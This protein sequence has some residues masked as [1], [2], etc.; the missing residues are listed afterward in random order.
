MATAW[1]SRHQA[2][3]ST[4]HSYPSCAQVCELNRLKGELFSFGNPVEPRTPSSSRETLTDS[5][6]VSNC[7]RRRLANSNGTP[8]KGDSVVL[9]WLFFSPGPNHHLVRCPRLSSSDSQLDS[10]EANLCTLSSV[11]LQR[12]RMQ[13]Q[14]NSVGFNIL[15]LRVH[16]ACCRSSCSV[17]LAA[18]V[19]IMHGSAD[20]TACWLSPPQP[21]AAAD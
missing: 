8:F 7:R 3:A 19:C 11:S 1:P 17:H 4:S 9:C 18:S 12:L 10:L 14:I 13:G 5:E 16:G 20:T 2:C 15:L 21:H 6:I